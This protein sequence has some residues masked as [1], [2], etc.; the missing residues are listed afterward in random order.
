[1][2]KSDHFLI[3]RFNVP[4]ASWDRDKAGISTLDT[5]WLE[6]RIALFNTF[7][8]PS[9]AGQTGKDFKWLIYCDSATDKRYVQQ[10]MESITLIPHAEL[11][12][13]KDFDVLK[14][15]LKQL[16]AQGASDYVITSRVDNDDALGRNYIKTIQ[17]SFSAED[18]TV[19]NLCGGVL[20]D[21][22]D[23][24]LTVLPDMRFNHF[25]SLIEKRKNTG[26]FLTV[27]GFSH[28]D[29]PGGIKVIDVMTK[30]AWLK[31]IHDRN[32]NSRTIGVPVFS[33]SLTRHFNLNRNVMPISLANS[34]VYVFK[35]GIDV[36]KR[37]IHMDHL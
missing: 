33:A 19:I 12:F 25:G 14:T 22:P 2:Y 8:V 35:R 9:I 18:L 5:K 4:I 37:K 13:V 30:N 28:H 11:R 31:I 6:H 29:P 7:C 15:D 17:S 16:I 1:V 10:I 34:I 21:L 26:E 27:M 3:T 24:I 23:H 20:Y 36:F 32:V